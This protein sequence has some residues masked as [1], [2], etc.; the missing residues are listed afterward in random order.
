[1]LLTRNH[2]S[3]FRVGIA[4]LT[5]KQHVAQNEKRN[6]DGHYRRK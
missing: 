4:L 1:V 3:T 2:S 5:S 6:K